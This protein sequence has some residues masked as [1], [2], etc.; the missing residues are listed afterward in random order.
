MMHTEFAIMML[1]RGKWW[2]ARLNG[3]KMI[4]DDHDKIVE[5]L[6][7]LKKFRAEDGCSAEAYKIVSR[8]VTDWIDE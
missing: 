6:E 2:I 8:E 5:N 4:T 1:V 7:W 3:R